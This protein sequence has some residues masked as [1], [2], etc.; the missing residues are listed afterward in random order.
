MTNQN[1]NF[2]FSYRYVYL[3]LNIKTLRSLIFKIGKLNTTASHFLSPF[4]LFSD[5]DRR[6]RRLFSRLSYSKFCLISLIFILSYGALENGLHDLQV[7]HSAAY[8]KKN[9]SIL[10][11]FQYF[12]SR[13]FAHWKSYISTSENVN[14]YLAIFLI[15]VVK[16]GN[17]AWIY[18]DILVIILCRALTDKL[19][20]LNREIEG[21]IEEIQVSPPIFTRDKG[22]IRAQSGFPAVWENVRKQYLD[23]MD[24]ILELQKFISPLILSCYGINMYLIIINVR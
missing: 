21:T 8:Q 10:P 16:S 17:Y 24:L 19:K 1:M 9:G 3:F 14:I 6:S 13:D 4:K 23:L 12:F 11:P 18:G 20:W 2:K 15:V 7:I 22:K 5:G